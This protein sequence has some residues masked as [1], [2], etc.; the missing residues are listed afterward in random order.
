[1]NRGRLFPLT[2]T[3]ALVIAVAMLAVFTATGRA[4]DPPQKKNK[5]KAAAAP[6]SKI[7]EEYTAKIK[8][9]TT[10]KYFL[11]ELVDH[12]PA[13]DKVPSP[14]KVLGYVVGT[15]N[16]LT[17]TKVATIASSRN[18]R[19]AF[20]CSPHRSEARKVASKCWSWSATK[21]TSPSSI[22]TKK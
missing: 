15:P 6:G 11:T 18:R 5:G 21:R 13:S 19:R 10:E 12:L 3:Y 4:A 16:K 22:A 9:Y 20:G 1:M 14:D 2:R 8:E 17:Y 7:N